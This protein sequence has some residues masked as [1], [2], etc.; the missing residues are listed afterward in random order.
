[1]V[2]ARFREQ[3]CVLAC[4]Y[5]R[6][7]SALTDRRTVTVTYDWRRGEPRG[8]LARTRETSA[9]DSRGDCI[10]CHQCVTVCPTGIDIRDGI[11]L[12]CVGCTAC[13]DA[14]NGVMDRIGKPAGLI[15]MTSDEAIRGN[16][17][18]WKTP[19]AAAY[20]LVWLGLVGTLAVLTAQ[21]RDVD[22]LILRQ[23][24]TLY[25]TLP[26]GEVA[27]FYNVEALNR[28]R[29]NA[30]FAID[31]VE[32]HDATVTALGPLGDIRPFAVAEARMLVR[33]KPHAMTGGRT[34]IR[35][36]IRTA[37]GAV[38]LVDSTFLGPQAP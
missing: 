9:S 34:A 30:T 6:M 11:Q 21:M 37:D 14:C 19:R 23:P 25:T 2:F 13:I 8:R 38:Q 5:G 18:S 4:P 17:A 35:F 10:D 16:R 27:N 12:E 20:A 3:A 26:T 15:R 7:L 24:G 32:P 29:S 31:V 33:L 28:T 22:V 1:M 36:A